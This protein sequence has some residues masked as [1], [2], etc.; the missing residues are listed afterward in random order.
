MVQHQGQQPHQ[1][2]CSTTNNS[3][4]LLQTTHNTEMA[5]FWDS[6]VDKTYISEE[7]TAFIIRLQ[8]KPCA[9]RLW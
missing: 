8:N 6:L 2:S 5:V 9:E 7:L 3:S 4:E 1:G